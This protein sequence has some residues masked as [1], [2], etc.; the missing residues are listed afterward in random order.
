MTTKIRF[1]LDID[2][3]I[4][5]PAAFVPALNKAFNK[6]LKLEDISSYDLTGIL[7]ITTEEFTQWMNKNEAMIYKQAAIAESA[8]HVIQKW[9]TQFELY[10]VTARGS[11]LKAVT[12]DWLNQYQ[13]PFHHLE[14]LGQHDK[15]EAVKKLKLDVFFEDKHDNAVAIAEQTSIPVILIDTPYNQEEDPTGVYRV[16][17][18]LEAEQ[19]IEQWI[20]ERKD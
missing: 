19:W 12:T 14:L 16:N 2:G 15:V 17:N 13:L 1:G 5:D 18:W 6:Q 4:T 10:Y 8:S 9:G 11:Y 7:G 20:Q 3:T